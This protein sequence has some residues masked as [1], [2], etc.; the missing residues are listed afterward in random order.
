MSKKNRIWWGLV[1]V[2]ATWWLLAND[3]P[4]VALWP[5]LVALFLVILLQRVVLGL[6]GGAFCGALLL[7]QGNPLA[8]FVSLFEV[9]LLPAFGSSWKSGAVLFTL[10]LGGFASLIERGGGMNALFRRLL[11]G[12]SS[13]RVEAVT[14][15]FGLVCFFDG[16]ANSLMVGRLF[17]DVADRAGVSRE[18]LSYIVD[19]TSS[20]VACLAIV[21]TWIAY[22]LAMIQDGLE[23]AGKSGEWTPYTLFW[24][25]LPYNF[26]CWFALILLAVVIWRGWNFGP[27]RRA[28][29]APPTLLDGTLSAG[30]ANAEGK[31]WQAFVPLGALL[32]LILG[33]IYLDG[34]QRLG[35]PFWPLG[36]QRV[37]EAF[38]KAE[39]AV[40]LVWAS[41]LATLIAAAL[42]PRSKDSGD[43][44]EKPGIGPLA[45]FEAGVHA[46]LGPILILFAAWMLSSV[47][48]ALGAVDALGGLLRDATS[49]QWLPAGVFVVGALTSFTTGTS[50]GTMGLLMPLAVPLCFHL[51]P[52]GATDAPELGVALAGVVGA[53]FSGA[54]FGD[55]CSP[56][57]DT[58]IVS[59]IACGL[60]PREH[61]KTQL[62]YALLAGGVALLVGFVPLLWIPTP[63]LLLGGGGGILVLTGW[64]ATRPKI[65]P[66]R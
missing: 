31:P 51:A 6:I 50:W 27:M 24:R 59:S 29:P 36:F 4:W 42:F 22:Q 40:V 18:K 10:V 62:P 38:G 1:P 25:S 48:E 12:G 61:V 34:T 21:S 54:V 46:M 30:P 2:A 53:V 63:G 44:E 60:E 58:T 55:H 3:A 20:A 33:G 57:S 17:R 8:A 52:E 35:V 15:A 5:S 32:V 64:W 49:L 39:A 13:R 26:Y 65:S 14:G 47:L 43:I 7:T 41:V 56:L 11:G 37:A 9:H 16:L 66:K 19:T 45:A 28:R 23:L